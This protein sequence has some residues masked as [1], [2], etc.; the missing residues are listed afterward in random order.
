MILSWIKLA[1]HDHRQPKHDNRDGTSYSTCSW[2]EDEAFVFLPLALTNCFWCWQQ[3]LLCVSTVDRGVWTT[4]NLKHKHS[5]LL[6]FWGGFRVLLIPDHSWHLYSKRGRAARWN[7][8]GIKRLGVTMAPIPPPPAKT[9]VTEYLQSIHAQ[10][11]V[12]SHATKA[13]YQVM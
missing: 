11:Y 1:W 2:V 3:S 8:P 12:N 4:A 5:L 13:R 7:L 6:V 9:S 10:Y